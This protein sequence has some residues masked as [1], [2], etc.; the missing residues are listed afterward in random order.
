MRVSARKVGR[1]VSSEGRHRELL[2]LTQ[3][4]K[5]TPL[6]NTLDSNGAAAVYCNIIEVNL[7]QENLKKYTFKKHICEK[8]TFE[9]YTFDNYTLEKYTGAAAVDCIE[10]EKWEFGGKGQISY[11]C[12]SRIKLAEF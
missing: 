6:T 3:L 4:L 10:A 5:N 2:N 9:K 8:Y 7:Q 12:K 11:Q 1:F